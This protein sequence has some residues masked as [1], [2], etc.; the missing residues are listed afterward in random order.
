MSGTL[1]RVTARWPALSAVALFTRDKNHEGN[2]T[3]DFEEFVSMMLCRADTSRKQEQEEAFRY[4]RGGVAMASDANLPSWS[5]FVPNAPRNARGTRQTRRLRGE[6]QTSECPECRPFVTR[7]VCD[8]A[9][10]GCCAAARRLT[11]TTHR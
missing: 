7:R 9:Q 3:I 2:G 4:F 6:R 8:V 10:S 5:P 1:T 11:E